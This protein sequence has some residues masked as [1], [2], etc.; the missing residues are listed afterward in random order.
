MNNKLE[1]VRKRFALT[2]LSHISSESPEK[3]IR[4]NW[5]RLDLTRIKILLRICLIQRTVYTFAPNL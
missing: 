5:D 4:K 1:G 3:K 2:V